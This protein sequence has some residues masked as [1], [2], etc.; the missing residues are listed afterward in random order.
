MILLLMAATQDW[1][2]PEEIEVVR[3]RTAYVLDQ[4]EVELDMIGSF[5]R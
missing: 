4:G 3:T 5:S 2:T 1:P